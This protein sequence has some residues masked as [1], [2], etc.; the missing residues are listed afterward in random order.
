MEG[1]KTGAAANKPAWQ[2]RKGRKREEV[3]ATVPGLADGETHQVV[4]RADHL[5]LS[6]LRGRVVSSDGVERK[7]AFLV[8]LARDRGDEAN[9]DLDASGGFWVAVEPGRYACEI[10]GKH[11]KRVRACATEVD[12]APGQT[13]EVVFVVEPIEVELQAVDGSGRPL[14]AARLVVR[15]AGSDRGGTTELLPT[16]GEGR[17]HAT[18]PAGEYVVEVAGREAARFTVGLGPAST[19]RVVVERR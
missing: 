19:V 13:A 8:P 7:R 16:D 18:L 1:P 6:T 15:R 9:L 4:G 2:G 17:A 14:A 12:L 10:A 3:I 5:M 11:G